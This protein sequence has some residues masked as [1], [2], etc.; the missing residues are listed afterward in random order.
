MGN[1]T[2]NFYDKDDCIFACMNND[3]DDNNQ[4]IYKDVKDE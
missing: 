2:F 4:V 3:R 1:C